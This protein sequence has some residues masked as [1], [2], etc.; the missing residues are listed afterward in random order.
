MTTLRLHVPDAA[1]LTALHTGRLPL[2]LRLRHLTRA[3]HRDVFYDTPDGALA[4]QGIDCRIR[5]SDDGAAVWSLRAEARDGLPERRVNHIVA[6]DVSTAFAGA[7]DAA[8]WLRAL[9]DVSLLGPVIEVRTERLSGHAAWGPWTRPRLRLVL[10]RSLVM[11]DDREVPIA[12]L[13]LIPGVGFGPS[14]RRVATRLIERHGLQY[15]AGGTLQRARQHLELADRWGGTPGSS[16]RREVAVLL[17]RD[18][19]VGFRRGDDGLDV[20]WTAGAGEAGCRAVLEDAFDSTQAQVRCLGLLPEKPWRPALE[21]W[22]ARH[23]PTMVEQHP[24]IE[25]LPLDRAVAFSG[26]PRLRQ[27]RALGALQ[28]ALQGDVMKLHTHGV[29]VGP[30]AEPA[31]AVPIAD[32]VDRHLDGDLSQLE[33]N[34]RLVALAHDTRLPLGDRL[35]FAAIAASNLD[36][37]A[38][39]RVGA[40]KRGVGRRR[41]SAGQGARAPEARLDAARIRIGALQNDLGRLFTDIL[42]PEIEG[43]GVGLVHWDEVTDAQRRALSR[44]FFES[45]R[46]RLVPLAVTAGHPFPRLRTLELT[47]V[48]RL[49]HVD[50]EQVHYA[51]VAVPGRVPRLIQVPDT[52]LWITAEDLIR[53]HGTDVFPTSE[54]LEAAAVRV[55]RADVLDYDDASST[56]LLRQVADAVDGRTAQPIVRI[57]FEREASEETRS[58]VLQEVRFERP[59][60]HSTIERTDVVALDRPLALRDLRPMADALIS[61]AGGTPSRP[62]PDDVPVMATLRQRDILVHFPYDDFGSTVERWLAEAADDPH[63][64]RLTLALYRTA[65][66]SSILAHLRRAAAAGK[67]V[68]ALVEL[69]ARFD[70]ARN[71]EAA[72]ALMD[73]GVRVV[74]GPAGLKL[75]SK[76]IQV[77]RREDGHLRRY[78]YIGTGNFNPATA[79]F[80]TDLG[81]FTADPAVGNDLA[82]LVD[83]LTAGGRRPTGSRLLVS[84]NDMLAGLLE[85]ITREVAHAQAGRTAR[86]RAKL[87]GLDDLEIIEALY[88]ASEAGVTI[89]LSI[90]GICRL[91]PG[92]AG[93]SSRIR[94][95]SLLGYFLEHARVIEFENGGQREYLIGSA[96]WRERNLRRRVEVLTPV[97]D[98]AGQ[99]YLTATLDAEFA[100]DAAWQLHPDG[101]WTQT[102]GAP[103]LSVSQSRRQADPCPGR[104]D[105]TRP[106]LA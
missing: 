101:S 74:Y 5:Y 97:R 40:L 31:V 76:V 52:T 25:W 33:F 41:V 85:R 78:S 106:L 49:R 26:T 47:I 20:F 35:S 88:N 61:R 19:A 2:G 96:D 34:G 44:Y 66:Q 17:A 38:A 80:Y 13:S 53:A 42:S 100:D 14:L 98:A 68:V 57:E 51:T 84:P 8:H 10:D 102:P 48:F 71:I 28:L 105:A 15:A 83:S 22:L 39:V 30:T 16:R 27:P 93:M 70:E 45:V 91:R 99:S 82:A 3:S 104:Q 46:P 18:G 79:R 11:A 73:A 63:V 7:S 1:D 86:I 89:D 43:H 77:L 59:S 64:E 67:E 95:I 56:D 72:R 69:R 12:T 60:D 54:I 81:L 90:R 50:T 23:L 87:N 58:L 62:F 75:H 92:V 94:V 37:F 65:A 24:S 32:D 29:T 55:I 9:I 36:E 103:A 4:R 21:V 6:G